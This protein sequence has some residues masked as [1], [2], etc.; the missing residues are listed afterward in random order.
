MKN[1]VWSL[2]KTPSLVIVVNVYLVIFIIQHKESKCLYFM[3]NHE[4]IHL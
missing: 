4:F 2:Q 1:D 3:Q